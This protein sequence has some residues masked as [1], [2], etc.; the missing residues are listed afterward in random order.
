MALV[1]KVTDDLSLTNPVG[2]FLGFISLDPFILLVLITPSSLSLHYDLII[3]LL[4]W[5]CSSLAPNPIPLLVSPSLSWV[6]SLN[7]WLQPPLTYKYY[8]HQQV[9]STQIPLPSTRPLY[10]NLYMHSLCLSSKPVLILLILG[11]QG[12]ILDPIIQTPHLSGH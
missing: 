11:N 2:P 8:S 4:T 6:T 9:S 3:F 1:L 10:P 12:I 5:C 7:P